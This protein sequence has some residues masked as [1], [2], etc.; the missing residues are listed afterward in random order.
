MT[1]T[2]VRANLGAKARILDAAE[3]LICDFGIDATSL[4]QITSLAEV[5]L[6][7][8]NYHFQSKDELVRA[9]YLRRLQ[10]IGR[11]RL[12]RLDALEA[13]GKALSLDALLDAFYAPVV[14]AATRLSAEGIN[15]PKIMGRALTDQ[16]PVVDRV[17][18]E[19]ILPMSMRFAR[20]FGAVLPH[21]TP[22]EVIWR[23]HLS[24]GLLA[25]ALG[26]GQKIAMLSGGVCRA[27]DMDEVL[28]QIKSFARAGFCA[29]SEERAA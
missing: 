28:G 10:P 13:D 14:A 12:S 17:F 16:H 3:R 11:E 1:D 4:R 21:L 29:P 20:A 18:Q 26:S 27:D 19:E 15:M 9:V 22:K 2:I 7:A 23:M 8:V 6:A 5:N 24:I 25:H